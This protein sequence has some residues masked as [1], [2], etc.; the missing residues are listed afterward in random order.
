MTN[1]STPPLTERLTRKQTE[2]AAQIDQVLSANL[3][4]LEESLKKY[5]TAAHG[6]IDEN[7]ASLQHAIRA[8]RICPWIYPLIATLLVVPDRPS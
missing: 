7:M 5:T 3:T 8:Y 2:Q 6:I 4:Q 1:T